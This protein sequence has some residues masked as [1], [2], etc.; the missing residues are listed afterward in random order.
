MA[1]LPDLTGDPRRLVP[2]QGQPPSLLDVPSGCAFHPRCALRGGRAL[3][4]E[5]RPVP[6]EVGP[7]HSAACHFHDE[8]RIGPSSGAAS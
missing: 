7:G 1:S 6:V 3:C 2:I 8:V 5:V 4:A